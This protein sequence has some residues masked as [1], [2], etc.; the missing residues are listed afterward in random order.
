MT[1]QGDQGIAK[2]VEVLAAIDRLID[3]ARQWE[4]VRDKDPYNQ[5]ARENLAEFLYRIF[6]QGYELGSIDQSKQILMHLSASFPTPTMSAIYFQNLE[7]ILERRRRQLFPAQIVLGLGAGR[8]GSTTLSHM[9]ASFH[10]SCATHEN[11]PLIYCNPEKEQLKFHFRGFQLLAK[12]F[13]LV[14][15]ASHWWLWAID[16]FFDEFPDGKAIRLY[17]DTQ[18]CVQ[19]FARVKG[20]GKGA[21]NL[22]CSREQN[23]VRE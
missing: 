20:Q 15:D 10:D 14:F 12:F 5:P 18:A 23:L 21:L 7:R 19:S 9:L 1:L 17:K 13:T 2:V 4:C 11:P 8:C 6:Y 16:R 3:E 22:G